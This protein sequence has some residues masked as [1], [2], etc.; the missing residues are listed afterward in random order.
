MAELYERI[1]GER[2]RLREVRQMM[3]AAV[4]LKSR[5]DKDYVTFYIAIGDYF[6]AAMDRLHEQDIRMGD[7]LNKKADLSQPKNQQAMKE[8]DARLEGNQLHLKELMTARD[9]L[10]QKN[11]LA[12]E[13]FEVAGKG[14]SDFIINN[15]G[16]HPGTNDMAQEVFSAED[17]NYMAYISDDDLQNQERLYD[18]VVAAKP[19]GL[20]LEN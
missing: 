13:E 10:K 7:L 9:S 16:H 19:K 17:W 4:E 5:G 14:Y 18:D 11:E 2:R 3:T 20:S 8:L 1:A 12:L 15:M 6:E